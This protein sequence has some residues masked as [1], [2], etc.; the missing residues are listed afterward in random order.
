[1]SFAEQEC[2]GFCSP[3]ALR[4]ARPV[5]LL[6]FALRLLVVNIFCRAVWTISISFSF[7]AREDEP[8]QDRPRDRANVLP[9]ERL[10]PEPVLLRGA[11]IF[12]P[13]GDGCPL[14]AL[15]SPEQGSLVIGRSTNCGRMNGAVLSSAWKQM[16]LG[17]E[18]RR[19]TRENLCKPSLASCGG[20]AMQSGSPWF[21]LHPRFFAISSAHPPQSLSLWKK[22]PVVSRQQANRS[23]RART[24]PIK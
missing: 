21:G 16:E 3:S 13:R 9:L 23:K 12:S 4:F 10:L 6:S 18:A 1:M 2:N 24:H 8:A 17:Y 20:A 15:P 19:V 5:R 14:V 11:P 22:I 7:A